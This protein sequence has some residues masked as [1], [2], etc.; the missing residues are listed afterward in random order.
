VKPAPFDYV[1]AER[2]RDAHAVL[3]AE[4]DEA[5]VLA[6][7]Q[8]LIPMLSMRLARPKVVVDIMRVPALA[9][10]DDD[11]QTMR[12]G[13]AVRQAELLRR[14]DLGD[15]QPLLGLALPWVGHAQTR[16]R[17]TLCGSAAHADPSA[18]IPLVLVALEGGIELSTRWRRRRV[19]AEA[20]FT[21]M[22]TTARRSDE[23]IEAIVVPCRQPDTGYAFREFGRRHGD[24]AIV[25]CAALAS[26]RGARLA[27]GGVADRPVARNFADLHGR[28]LDE[29]LETFA[30]ELEARDDLHAT[31]AYRRALVRQ[32]G[33][34]M[35]E[36]ARRCRG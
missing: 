29:A 35:I 15:K 3:A 25:A 26:R 2:V 22:M 16:S 31:A 12:I 24:F 11:G 7:G 14:A 9:T 30:W 20:F 10:V 5:C 27:V 23:L 17:G 34:Q 8:S 13:A 33:R 32:I 19:P 1:C 6:G 36:E 28:A 18:E 4:G 21:G